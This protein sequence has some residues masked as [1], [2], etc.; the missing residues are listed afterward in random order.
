MITIFVD[1]TDGNQVMAYYRG[2]RVDPKPWTDQGYTELFVPEEH[3][4]YQ[5]LTLQ[6]RNCRFNGDT[7]SVRANPIN[8]IK[9]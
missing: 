9:R 7:I 6:K 8:E 1:S 2:C 3:P 4:L 5:T